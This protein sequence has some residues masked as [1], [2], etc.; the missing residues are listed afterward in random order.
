MKKLMN[1]YVSASMLEKVLAFLRD[2]AIY[3]YLIDCMV[4][5]KIEIGAF[6]LYVG[7]V[8]GFEA[9]MT[10]VFERVQSL[11]QNNAVMNQYIE[12][13]QSGIVETEGKKLPRHAG[14]AHEIRLENVCFRYDGTEEDVLHNVNL[15]VHTGEKLALVGVNGAGKTTLVKILSGLYKPTSGK[16]YLDGED[17]SEL[18]PFAYYKE[19]SVVFQDVFAFSFP[20]ADN[21]SCK[22]P[23]ETDV[24]RLEDCLKKADLWEKVQSLEK[25]VQTVMNK[26]LDKE[27]VLLSGGEMQKLMLARALYKEAPVVILDEPTA[28]LDPIAESEMYQKYHE[29]TEGK[30]SIFI[31][32]RLS[33]TRFCNR[34]LFLENGNIAEE[35][36]HEELMERQGSY[37]NMFT[38]Q[39][40]YYQ[41]EP[42]EKGENCYA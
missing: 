4:Q 17:V 16:V 34:I 11:L 27:G 26:D 6:L 18:N 35:G 36:S 24:S 33:S 37:A 30:T 15:T 5:G 29:L 22:T 20:L 42:E 13:M 1:A 39:A 38:V 41:K 8:A 25:G 14:E 9:W 40:Q 28:A 19:F 2:A 23:E 21:V 31:S 32:H 3:W 12:F 7:T 10:G